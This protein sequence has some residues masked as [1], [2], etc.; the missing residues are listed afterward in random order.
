MK[1]LII[2]FS[3]LFY[4]TACE[5]FLDVQPETELTPELALSD[6]ESIVTAL[7]GAYSGLQAQGYYGMQFVI[8]GDASSDNGKIPSDREAAGA[9]ADRIPFA[10]TLD[11][12]A[13]NTADEFWLD[14]YEI[15]AKVNNILTRLDEVEFETAF[16]NRVRGECLALRAM[17]HF[18]LSRVFAQDYNF[19]QDQ[20][21]LAVPYIFETIPGSTPERNTIGEIYD[22][23]LTDIQEAIGLLDGPDVI[24]ERGLRNGDDFYFANYYMALGVLA[25]MHFYATDYNNALQVANQI[26]DGPYELSEYTLGNYTPDALDE[27]EFINEWYSLAPIIEDEAIMQL[28][29]DED[30][31]DFASRSYIDIF[32]AN[33]GNA[34]HAIS[35][36]L[37]D[38]Y[39]PADLRRN[40]YKIE[41]IDYHVFKYPGGL[42]LDADAHAI[43]LM[44]LSE[45]V[46][47]AAECEARIGDSDR[48]RDLVNLITERANASAI[49]SMGDQ[50][51]E[52]IITERQKELAFEGH[53]LY[54]LKRLQRGF[55]RNDC[56]LTNGNCTVSY[57]S[58]LYAWPIPIS[59]INA[60]PSIE[61]NPI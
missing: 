14:A 42:G 59:E 35:D 20:S 26:I 31:G 2:V 4:C 16:E 36:D 13:V 38:L 46:L 23:A 25:R 15:I 41:Q 47:M 61:Q 34:A 17:T 44:R 21:H 9:N 29:T 60:N 32:V 48:A 12:N 54:D 51:I 57:P 43:A 52:D 55:E 24:S 7:N 37:L 40:W 45:F 19:S 53:R 8:I 33:N 27:M 18:D 1:K 30:D 56:T 49:T 3:I 6:Q 58:N 22:F 50:L 5:K 39:E 10:Y 28:D 11:I